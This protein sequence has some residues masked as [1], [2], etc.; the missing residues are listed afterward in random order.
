M[1]ECG[2]LGARGMTAGCLA[3]RIGLVLRESSG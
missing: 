2:A 1:T 3:P